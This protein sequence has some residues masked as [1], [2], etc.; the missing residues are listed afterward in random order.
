MRSAW[1]V[2]WL[3]V[4]WILAADHPEAG[5]RIITVTEARELVYLVLSRETKALPGLT[6]L[7][8]EEPRRGT[9]TFDVLWSNPGLGSV[10]VEFYCVN[11]RTAEVWSWD[12]CEPITSHAL[13]KAQQRIRRRLRLPRAEKLG[14]DGTPACCR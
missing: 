5:G 10:H 14:P 3:L 13:K 2:A 11:L 4:I 12:E 7:P 1:S 9:V 6:L 8:H